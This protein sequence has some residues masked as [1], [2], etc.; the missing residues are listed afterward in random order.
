MSGVV[1]RRGF[2]AAALLTGLVLIPAAGARS[3]VTLGSALDPA[4]PIFP[5]TSACATATADSTCTIMHTIVPGGQLTAPTNGVIVRWRVRRAGGYPPT[6]ALRVIRPAAG[7]FTGLSA[8][9]P[10]QLFDS[11][12][13]VTNTALPVLAGDRIGLNVADHVGDA[14]IVTARIGFQYVG[15]HPNFLAGTLTPTFGKDSFEP[16]FNADL[17]PDAD[18][19]GRGDETQDTAQGA[20]CLTV[21]LDRRPRKRIKTRR[22]RA[23]VVFAFQANQPLAIQQP[24]TFECNLD[25]GGAFRPCVSPATYRVGRGDHR[26]E[27]RPK[28]GNGLLGASSVVGFTV[29]RKGKRR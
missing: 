29:K 21:T 26:F 7:G 14:E 5:I 1:R 20:P 28:A 11:G 10:R 25:G 22:K 15:W 2:I 8:S 24:P 16:L 4:E 19:D 23:K 27:V 3:A 12:T 18:C 9:A 13:I 17:E 6:V